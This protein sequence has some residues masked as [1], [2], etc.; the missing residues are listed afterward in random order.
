MGLNI[1]MHTT[2]NN[3]KKKEKK[4]SCYI[5]VLPGPRNEYQFLVKIKTVNAR[6]I[7]LYCYPADAEQIKWILL[8]DSES[9]TI[10][11]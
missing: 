3:R 10:F 9:L 2:T 7:R 4:E 5:L 8:L 11:G 6:N 1:K